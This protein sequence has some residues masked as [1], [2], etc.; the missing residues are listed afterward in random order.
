MFKH[1]SLVD[2]NQEEEDFLLIVILQSDITR[3]LEE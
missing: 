1:G 2:Y 3:E